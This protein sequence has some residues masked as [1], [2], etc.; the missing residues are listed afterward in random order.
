[1]P[2]SGV[3]EDSY[4]CHIYKINKLIKKKKKRKRR[5]PGWQGSQSPEHT[6]D[7]AIGGLEDMG[8]RSVRVPL[9]DVSCL[10]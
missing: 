5:G 10:F 2:F 9:K 3:S 7:Q 6:A 4:S 1:M 8:P